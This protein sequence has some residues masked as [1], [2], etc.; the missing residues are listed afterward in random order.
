MIW[1]GEPKKQTDME[2][3]K[4]LTDKKT[5]EQG[6]T[7]PKSLEPEDWEAGERTASVYGREGFPSSPV[8][9]HLCKPECSTI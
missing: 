7:S 6:H 1:S 9:M 3:K 4:E 5:R 8:V 2:V